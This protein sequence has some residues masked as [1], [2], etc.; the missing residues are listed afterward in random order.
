[1]CKNFYFR[2]SLKNMYRSS[3][4][5]LLFMLLLIALTV[6]TCL[7]LA[8]WSSIN[9]YLDACDDVYS[10]IGV[11][12]YMGADYPDT[13]VY[14]EGLQEARSFF[15]E[16]E[17]LKNEEVISY[18]ANKEGLGFIESFARKDVTAHTMDKVV[19]TV[20]ATFEISDAREVIGTS[21]WA[22]DIWFS[23]QEE[24]HREFNIIG[25]DDFLSAYGPGRHEKVFLFH[26]IQ[27]EDPWEGRDCFELQPTANSLA[28]DDV[29]NSELIIDITGEEDQY[30]IDGNSSFAMLANTYA[31]QRN[32]LNIV[33]SGNLDVVIN[34]HQ[35][36]AQLIE[37]RLFNESEYNEGAPVLILSK[38]VA[39]LLNVSLGD[40]VPMSFTSYQGP[41]LTS[42]FWYGNGFDQTNDYE[43][44]G[45][46]DVP[47]E[48]NFYGYIPENQ[49]ISYDTAQ[50]GYIL[51]IV[52]IDNELV[53]KFYQKFAPSLPE[54]CKITIYDQGYSGASEPFDHIYRIAVIIATASVLTTFMILLLY[55][56]LFVYRQKKVSNIMMSLGTSRSAVYRY[57]LYG[58]SVLTFISVVI[59]VVLS[60]SMFVLIEEMLANNLSMYKVQDLRYSISNLSVIEK[61][62]FKPSIEYSFL[63]T[64][65]LII[66]IVAVLCSGYFTFKTFKIKRK[67]NKRQHLRSLSKSSKLPGKFF[68]YT[69]LSFARVWY[70]SILISLLIAASFVF[71]S[72]LVHTSAQYEKEL[73]SLK[74]NTEIQVNFTD[75]HGRNVLKVVTP[76]IILKDLM[77]SGFIED[78]FITRGI[79]YYHLG[80]S[81]S[82]GITYDVDRLVLTG[83]RFVD[84][85]A[86]PPYLCFTN[87]I[88]K[89]PE[90]SY[91]KGVEV[92]Y[93]EGYDDT[94]FQ[95]D[96]S[97][98]KCCI[99]SEE[100]LEEY[101]VKVGDTICLYIHYPGFFENGPS[102]DVLMA[103]LD[104][105]IIGSFVKES[106]L[107]HIYCPM[108]YHFD[109][110]IMNQSV[111]ESGIIYHN[112][113]N[114]ELTLKD[115]ETIDAFREYMEEY[116]LSSAGTIKTVRSFVVINDKLYISTLETL[117]QQIAHVKMLYPILYALLLGI[118]GI[119]S[120]SLSFSRR[121][122]L[123]IMRGLG[124]SKLR[125]SLTFVL[126]HV[127][128][129]IIGFVG[130]LAVSYLVF[131]S[132]LESQLIMML[133]FAAAYMLGTIVSLILMNQI[134]VF[135]VMK[136]E[137]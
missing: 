51:G 102:L 5:T 135:K 104:F 112:F 120:Y 49:S 68:K 10:T 94:F 123:S 69:L 11:I 56:Y 73:D 108:G 45:I 76:A 23:V 105:K 54:R 64:I 106:S 44:V 107:D 118:G 85:L 36:R 40:T 129:C 126:E 29:K 93:L 72:Q 24:Y 89:T 12:E 21:I 109:P 71:V 65:G 66:L 16:E 117:E 133:G 91:S 13:D 134:K 111:D 113:D 70:R 55:G 62:D 88:D 128:F 116:G 7:S 131:E 103:G 101:N 8:T 38:A 28:P 52:E 9:Q 6:L 95:S 60:K 43:V 87:D 97:Q 82:D 50:V 34:F 121:K 35:Q 74:K 136:V 59:G 26:G 47:K 127:L 77:D 98:E 92:T 90:F 115:T 39:G 61:V 15:T 48:L 83:E 2:N 75:I 14:D 122:E 25:I 57:Y 41:T 119:I 42:N 37:G 114:I 110:E 33:A 19:L 58:S 46:V 20:D 22:K 124:A 137:D 84:E 100:Y 17:L 30:S 96:D 67:K 81:E 125:I 86:M 18:E 4:K 132:I 99:V 31:I 130:G 53:N 3:F 80:V 27:Y 1:M 78:Y 32:S 79:P 63:I